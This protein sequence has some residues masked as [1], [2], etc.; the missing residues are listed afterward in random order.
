MHEI[1]SAYDLEFHVFERLGGL[2]FPTQ[3]RLDAAAARSRVGL[4]WRDDLEVNAALDSSLFQVSPPRG[5]R[6]VDLAHGE[7]IP[8]V[9][10]PG[11]PP[12]RE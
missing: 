11:Q 2:R 10:L 7:P 12:R 5:V 1:A 6:I 8:P 4:D 3:V 9:D